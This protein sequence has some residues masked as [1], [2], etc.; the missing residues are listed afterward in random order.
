MNKLSKYFSLFKYSLSN[1]KN[2]LNLLNEARQSRYNIQSIQKYQTRP[3]SLEECLKIFF[4]NSEISKEKL[5]Q[6]TKN[7]ETHFYNYFKNLKDAEFPSKK[8]PYPTDYSIKSD[9]CLFLYRSFIISRFSKLS[10]PE[11]SWYILN[12][13]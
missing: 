8:K 6:D 13:Q 12:V 2:G 9:S 10:W 1:P 4:P 3:L 5:I 7:L 11:H